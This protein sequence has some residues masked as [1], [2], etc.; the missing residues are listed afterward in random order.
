MLNVA[1]GYVW[2]CLMSFGL[3][4]FGLMSFGLMSF[5][6]LSV[7]RCIAPSILKEFTVLLANRTYIS[8]GTSRIIT[9]CTILSS[10]RP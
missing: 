3:M 6:I 1:F 10:L 5:G 8:T 7:Y 4:S 9:K 2:F